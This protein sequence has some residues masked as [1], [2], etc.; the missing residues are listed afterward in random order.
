[1]NMANGSETFAIRP[2]TEVI[3][4]DGDGAKSQAHS[5]CRPLDLIKH[6]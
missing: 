2:V 5:M 3:E 6:T 1:M 4:C